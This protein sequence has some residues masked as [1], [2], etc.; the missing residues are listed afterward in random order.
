MHMLVRVVHTQEKAHHIRRDRP[1][2]RRKEKRTGVSMTVGKGVEKE[3]ISH[4]L[5]PNRK[6]MRSQRACAAVKE[7]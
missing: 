4:M 1:T 6:R 2:D 5:Y 3:R 7:Y